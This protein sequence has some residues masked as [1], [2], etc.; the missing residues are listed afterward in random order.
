MKLKNK[1]YMLVIIVLLAA[2]FGACLWFFEENNTGEK[3]NES[4]PIA[5][6]LDDG[7]TYPTIVA[8]TSMVESKTSNSVYD[9]Y[10]MHPGEF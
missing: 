4:I 5:M 1:W 8:I 7:Y 3:V 9:Y 6:A 10:I 2:V